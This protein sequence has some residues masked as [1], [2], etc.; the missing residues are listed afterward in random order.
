MMANLLFLAFGVVMW[1]RNRYLHYR[2]ALLETEKTALPKAQSVPLEQPTT[3]IQAIPTPL[4]SVTSTLMET[5]NKETLRPGLEIYEKA[6]VLLA[7]GLKLGEVSKQTG[8]SLS[9][10]RLIQKMNSR[11]H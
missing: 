9:E 5:K 1:R 6:D 4:G 3:F 11:Q 8:L 7:K 10:L 2:L